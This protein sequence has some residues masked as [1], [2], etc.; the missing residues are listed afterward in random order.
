MKKQQEKPQKEDTGPGQASMVR[1]YFV[2]VMMMLFALAIIF[3][4]VHIQI[5][6]ASD[7]NIAAEEREFRFDDNIE[8]LRGSI[9]SYDGRL[10]ATSIPVFEVRMDVAS[11]HISDQDF[12]DSVSWLAYGLSKTFGDFTNWEYKQRL[13]E[14]RKKGNRY[15]LIQR[16]VTFD[17]LTQLQQMPIFNR[18][19]HRGGM[20]TIRST[21]REYPFDML[22]KRTIGYYLD[23]PIPS[24]RVLVGLEGQYNE[25]LQG[26]K[27]RQLMQRM[28]FGAWKPIA[29]V[30]NIEPVN[31]KDVVTTINSY[32]QDVAHNSLL[33]QLQLHAAE[34][35]TVVLMEVKTGEIRAMVNLMLDPVDGQYKEVYNMA[36]GELFEPGSTF[37]LPSLMVAVEDGIVQKIDSVYIGAGYTT[38]NNRE[39]KDSHKI[40]P[41]GWITPEECMIFSSNVGISRI[42]YDNYNGK[43]KDFYQGLTHMFPPE[44]TGI[45]IPGESTPF[46]KNPNLKDDRNYWSAVTLPWMSIGYE[47]L[48]TP[49]QM[50]TFYNAVAN[51]GK[52]VKPMMVKEIREGGTTVKEFKPEVIKKSIC[53]EQTIKIVQSYLEQTVERGTAKNVQNADY[54]IAGKTGTAKINEG[55]K[56]ISKYNASFVGYFP[57]DDPK[58]SCIVVIYK[59]N[60]GAFYASQVAAP[61]FK[62]IADM[63]YAFEYT[64]DPQNKQ[65]F[66]AHSTM[67]NAPP[68]KVPEQIGDTLA[69]LLDTEQRHPLP[70]EERP[71]ALPDVTGLGA[72]DAVYLL[73]NLGLVV[74]LMGKG[75]VKKQS[76][77]PGIP[78][79]TGDHIYL[80][81]EI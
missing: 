71:D 43:N 45:D 12:N 57:A 23:H 62:E 13:I 72:R 14:A 73:E 34:K 27:G 51:N 50:L 10:M 28:A 70:V 30:N 36:V 42:I 24:E 61:V 47:V 46:I 65:E 5:F 60:Q 3:R 69:M 56:Y 75:M 15:F 4:A 79:K 25:Y 16:N 76:L 39:M 53:S 41:D 29:H 1:V 33:D 68:K 18:G 20:I 19:K 9:Y 52:M 74:K 55:G 2:Y 78:Y 81:L 59:P 80:T 6:E 49:L 38:F 21:R 17:Q 40:D 63:V 32:L 31:G 22:A 48:I 7:L 58:F 66:I 8:A 37:K 77:T 44:K 11:H 26:A 54:K 67:Y 64:I 35:G